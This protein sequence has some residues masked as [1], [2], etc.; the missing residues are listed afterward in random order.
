MKHFLDKGR[1]DTLKEWDEYRY[2]VASSVGTGLNRIVEV[3]DKVIIKSHPTLL[4]SELL[5][6]KQVIIKNAE[7]EKA[8]DIQR[9]GD[10][11]KQIAQKK[12]IYYR[13]RDLPQARA[14][15]AVAP[16]HPRRCG[17]PCGRPA[18]TGRGRGGG[19]GARAG[20]GAPA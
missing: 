3:E 17:R 15:Q 2:D 8:K 11:Q 4:F 12:E 18:G 1:I 10:L 14:A 19:A 20:A 7:I 9:N 5:K 13:F 6:L 16:H